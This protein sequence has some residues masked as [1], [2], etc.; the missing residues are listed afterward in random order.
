MKDDINGDGVG[1]LNRAS[2]N[3]TLGVYDEA[4]FFRPRVISS[5]LTDS[6]G[7]YV[8]FDLL[9]GY[10]SVEYDIDK[11]FDGY[12]SGTR[13]LSDFLGSYYS[14]ATGETIT[15]VDFV[16]PPKHEISGR[17][18]EKLHNND[19]AYTPVSGAKLYLTAVEPT[20]VVFYDAITDSLGFFAFYLFPSS[21]EIIA[22]DSNWNHTTTFFANVTA[23][24]STGNVFVLDTS[25]PSL[26][27]P[28]C[29]IL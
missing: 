25:A 23:G 27:G 15:H 26:P 24:N 29:S 8:F 3:I 1:D 11:M 14:L 20:E 28:L 5:V 10:Y 16:V 6:D 19:G 13:C 4:L 18:L 21:Y 2:V 7:N 12:F 9:G 22:S 17:V